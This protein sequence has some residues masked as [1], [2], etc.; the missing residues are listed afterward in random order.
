MAL[1]AELNTVYQA[2]FPEP[3]PARTT[4]QAGLAHDYRI[5]IDAIAAV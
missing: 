4:V 5:E 1:F 3:R 2:F